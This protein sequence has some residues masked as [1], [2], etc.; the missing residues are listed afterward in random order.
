MPMILAANANAQGSHVGEWR[1]PTAWDKPA[2]NLENAVRLAQIA[3]AG[4]M[5]LLFLADG[6]GVRNLDK[7]DLFAATAPSDRPGIFEP[8]TLLSALSMVTRHIGLVATATTTYDEPFGVA[9]RF[10]SLDHLSKGRAGWNL[11]TTSNPGD[12]LNFS[13]DEHVARADRYERAGE[14]AEIV[15][16]LWDSWADDAFPQDKASGKYLDPKKVHALNH[17]GK[18]FRVAGPLNAP[19]PPQGHPLIFSAGQS[20]A[21]KE[22]SASTADC[23]FAI[24][25][26]IENAQKLYA[27]LKGRMAK[28]GRRPDEM[29]ILAGTTIVVGETEAEAERILQELEE[30]VPV[31]VGLDYLSKMVGVRMADYP[32]DGPMPELSGEHIGPTA[33]GHSIVAMARAKGLTVRE[34]Y[35]TVLPQ[36]AGN[37][38][39]GDPVQV[40]DKLEAWYRGKACDGFMIAAPVVPTGM[41]RFTQLVIPILQKRGLFRTE[42]EGRTLRENLGLARPENR[43]FVPAGT[44]AMAK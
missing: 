4:K 17:K 43:F 26:T 9:R 14:F 25:G 13:H 36:M 34:T 16:G 38:F 41:E 8:V 37:I 28:Y 35:K 21:G 32:L 42:Y 10:A 40:A 6:N 12:A 15:K 22:L 7:P 39:R 24:E 44:E 27:D 5:D 23:V 3:E 2:A 11:V 1:H 31:P 33:I 29:K 19:R 18:H 20:D 30:L